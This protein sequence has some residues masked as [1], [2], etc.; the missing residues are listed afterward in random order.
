MVVAEVGGGVG[1]G[2]REAATMSPFLRIGFSSFEMDP[3]LAYHEE[4]LNP[5]C[6]VYMKEV[7]DTGQFDKPSRWFG[8]CLIGGMVFVVMW[9]VWVRHPPECATCGKKGE[10]FRSIL[11]K[12]N[13]IETRNWKKKKILHFV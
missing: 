10:Q 11:K 3:G 1:S 12:E 5:Y 9:S 13:F 8:G 7:V 4:A 6:A 2:E